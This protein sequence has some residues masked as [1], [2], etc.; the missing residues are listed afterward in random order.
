M[1]NVLYLLT[2]ELVT[3]QKVISTSSDLLKRGRISEANHELVLERIMPKVEEFTKA[4][5]I[6]TD[7]ER[8]G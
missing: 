2:K 6:L 5:E 4:I 8:K 1:K 3:D 7:Y